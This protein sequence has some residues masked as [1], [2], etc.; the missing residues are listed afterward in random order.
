MW[1]PEAR[2][3]A[4]LQK[5]EASTDIDIMNTIAQ[6]KNYK[7]E[8][9]ELQSEFLTDLRNLSEQVKKEEIEKRKDYLMPKLENINYW[10]EKS[11]RSKIGVSS[12]SI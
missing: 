3:E 11:V 4:K 6:E 9:F 12:K 10:I 1:G 7:T 8:Y 2:E 5:P